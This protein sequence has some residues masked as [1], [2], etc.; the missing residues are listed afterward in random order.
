[1]LLLRSWSSWAE[2]SFS[3][4]SRIICWY[5][6]ISSSFAESAACRRR[7][8]HRVGRASGVMQENLPAAGEPST[9]SDAHLPLLHFGVDGGHYG[10]ILL[11][12]AVDLLHQLSDLKKNKNKKNKEEE[13]EEEQQEEQ[14]ALQLLVLQVQVLQRLVELAVGGAELPLG[15]GALVPAGR[16]LLLLLQLPAV[17]VHVLLQLLLLRAPHGY[18]IYVTSY[19]TRGTLHYWCLHTVVYVRARTVC[20]DEVLRAGPG[21]YAYH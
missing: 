14:A 12:S 10:V 15:L 20:P 8:S 13:E 16:R 11:S 9:Q 4:W 19:R 7:R 2:R 6:L 17:E 5:K 21:L 1:M 3:L 18:E